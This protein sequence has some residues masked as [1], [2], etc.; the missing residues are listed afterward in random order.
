VSQKKGALLSKT[1]T[2]QA[3]KMHF[4]KITISLV[5]SHRICFFKLQIMVKDR[6]RYL[7]FKRNYGLLLKSGNWARITS[8][9]NTLMCF[10]STSPWLPLWD[11]KHDYF[12]K[13]YHQLDWCWIPNI[14]GNELNP[15][16]LF[17][18]W[19]PIWKIRL[20]CLCEAGDEESPKISRTDL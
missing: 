10:S 1:L 13:F 2:A 8:H 16:Y 20:P 3:W 12:L 4:N 7:F 14:R 17:P 5:F 11:R 6:G 9:W 19:K 15:S 18:K